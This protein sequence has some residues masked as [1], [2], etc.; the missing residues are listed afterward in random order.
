MPGCDF[1]LHQSFILK[2]N[3]G[4]FEAQAPRRTVEYTIAGLRW[5]KDTFSKSLTFHN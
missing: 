2:M 5:Q 4:W 1:K 3:C